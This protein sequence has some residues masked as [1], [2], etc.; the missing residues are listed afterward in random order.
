MDNHT[1]EEEEEH[2]LQNA[3]TTES[4]IEALNNINHLSDERTLVNLATNKMS[5]EYQGYTIW[6]DDVSRAYTKAYKRMKEKKQENRKAGEQE[7]MAINAERQKALQKTERQERQSIVSKYLESKPI[8]YTADK[9][10]YDS[11]GKKF[12]VADY[13][14]GCGGWR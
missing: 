6:N 11:N 10:K 8:G 9:Y 3:N 1:E 2:N 14:N 13:T 4:L 5:T 7:R 12:L